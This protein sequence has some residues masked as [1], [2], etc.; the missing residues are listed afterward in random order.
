MM[1][2][3]RIG[4][5]AVAVA[6]LAGTVACHRAP[7]ELTDAQLTK[8]LHEEHAAATDPQAPLD[9]GAVE[10]LRAW[11]GNSDL[12]RNLPPAAASDAAKKT[13]RDR[14]D[15][16]VADSTR[17]PDKFRID[18]L[19]TAATVRQAMALLGQR[20]AMAAIPRAGDRPPAALMR[21]SPMAPMPPMAPPDQQ[22]Y[23]PADLSAATTA[24]D[25]LDGMCQQ[26]KDAAASGKAVPIARYANFCDRRIEE[27]RRRISTLSA[28]A[29]VNPRE[30]QMLTEN[31]QRMVAIGRRLT[32][33]PATGAPP[34]SH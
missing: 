28:Q 6:C 24:V 1:N 23:G 32:N 33:E 16:W 11:S 8:L 9:A 13:C 30:V 5:L 3:G 21:R 31:A 4:F 18:D 34:A 7:R 29:N 26:A 12:M 10:C 2:T 14:L 19:T 27:L 17:N 15:G 20:Q 25:E 22:N